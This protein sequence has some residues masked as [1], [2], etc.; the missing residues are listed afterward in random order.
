[1]SNAITIGE[2]ISRNYVDLSEKLQVIADFAAENPMEIATRSLRSLAATNGVSPATFSRLA[3]ALGYNDYE[4]LREDARVEME[5][6]VA[7]FSER[8]QSLR[9]A[10]PAL[11]AKAHLHRQA[12]ACINNIE[13]LVRDVPEEMLERVVGTIDAAKTVLLVGSLGSAG[14]VEYFSYLTNWFTSNWLVAGRNGTTLGA[15][16]ARLG[17]GDAVLAISKAPYAKRTI[18]ALTV[19]KARGVSV[20]VITDSHASPALRFSDGGFIVPSESPHF[21]SSY[22]ATLVIIETIVT[23][24]LARAGDGAE[25]MIR[26]M[27]KQIHDLGETWTP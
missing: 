6:K 7:S 21:F 3:R 24:L 18:T 5:R 25:D 27:E 4:E 1:M 17:P 20:F 8:A 13:T 22:T 23:M 10:A 11:D 14:F 2:R 16:L 26:E 12:V 19:A 15:T 9:A